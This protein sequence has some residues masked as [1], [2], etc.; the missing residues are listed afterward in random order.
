VSALPDPT[1]SSRLARI[2]KRLE[3]VAACTLGLVI[4]LCVAAVTGLLALDVAAAVIGFVLGGGLL[5]GHA[6]V[7][8]ALERRDT[9]K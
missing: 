4:A 3:H 1:V 9:T 6:I 7:R 2:G 5:G 8:H